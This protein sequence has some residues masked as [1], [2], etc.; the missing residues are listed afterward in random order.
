MSRFLLLLLLLI[1]LSGCIQ[2]QPQLQSQPSEMPNSSNSS[3]PKPVSDMNEIKPDSTPHLNLPDPEHPL[4]RKIP[5]P[6]RKN[7]P[8]T[9]TLTFK[10]KL[11]EDVQ[12][13]PYNTS[14]YKAGK[15]DCSNM[16]ALLY[17]W[18]KLK[19]YDVKFVC[20]L[21]WYTYEN[22]YYFQVAHC[23]VFVGGVDYILMQGEPY[24]NTTV[25]LKNNSYWIEAT[26]KE[27][28]HD[29]NEIYKGF[30]NFK[31]IVIYDDYRNAAIP[32]QLGWDKEFS[33]DW[34]LKEHY[35]TVNLTE[36]AI[37][38]DFIE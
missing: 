25:K 6:V 15:F 16:H 12:S 1:L 38:K 36:I 29:L 24:R 28:F 2:P 10:E 8:S 31:R 11:I 14:D 3:I 30:Y 13:A 37:H 5:L 19:G 7:L 9:H 34:Y 18:L 32:L 4:H 35:D 20:G 27:V 26:R 21:G 17:D 33:Y 23:W 22:I